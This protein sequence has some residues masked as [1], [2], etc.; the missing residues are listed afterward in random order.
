VKESGIQLTTAEE[1]NDD[2][3]TAFGRSL[4]RALQRMV[5]TALACPILVP[6]G[7]RSL[8]VRATCSPPGLPAKIRE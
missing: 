7:S 4:A 6:V 5:A 2:P 8:P 1:N 3:V